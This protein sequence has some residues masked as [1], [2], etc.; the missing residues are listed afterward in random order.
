M[1]GGGGWG[2]F[3]LSLAGRRQSGRS[4]LYN[5]IPMVK[6]QREAAR[7]GQEKAALAR[8]EQEAAVAAVATGAPIPKAGGG[9]AGGGGAGA[10]TGGGATIALVQI[11]GVSTTGAKQK[12]SKG[13]KHGAAATGSSSSGG[14]GGGG[15][16]GGSGRSK[17]RGKR[18]KRGVPIGRAEAVELLRRTVIDFRAAQVGAAS[19]GSAAVSVSVGVDGGGGG[20]VENE[21]KGGSAAGDASLLLS[22]GER[23]GDARTIAAQEFAE[24][25]RRCLGSGLPEIALEVNGAEYISMYEVCIYYRLLALIRRAG[26]GFVLERAEVGK[27]RG[28]GGAGIVVSW[29]SWQAL[30]YVY[31]GIVRTIRLYTR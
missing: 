6:E 30:C 22:G 12:T 5:S 23:T 8:K 29:R 19:G 11:K 24:I 10:G 7:K 26:M 16:A 13:K 25:A 9:G 28:G 20:G 18:R 14:G 17:R 2:A 4:E 1:W 27:V 3:T 15:T 21:R 31:R